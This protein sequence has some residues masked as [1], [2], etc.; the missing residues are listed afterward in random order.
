MSSGND[1][2]WATAV[3]L[4]RD[5]ERTIARCVST[6]S[7]DAFD[8]VLVLD[9][10]STDRTREIVEQFDDDR[11]EIQHVDWPDDFS[12][13]RNLAIEKIGSGWVVFID[14]DEWLPRA[15]TQ[16]LRQVLAEA[17]RLQG[18]EKAVLRPVVSEWDSSWSLAPGRIMLA[19]G[20]VRFAGAV[21][22]E[23]RLTEPPGAPASWIALNLQIKHDGYRPEVVRSKRKRERNTRLIEKCRAAE[24][25]NPRWIFFKVRDQ[26]ETLEPNELDRLCEKLAELCAAGGDARPAR[27]Y[28]SKTL[29]LFTSKLAYEGLHSKLRDVAD[30]LERVEVGNCDS[31]YYRYVLRLADVAAGHS[32]VNATDLKEMLLRTIDV[33]RSVGDNIEGALHTA[34]CHIDALIAALLDMLGRPDEANE[35]RRSIAAPWTDAFFEMSKP[36]WMDREGSFRQP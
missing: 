28:Y 14:S 15:S 25:D 22:E 16:S 32:H 33:R 36:R 11:I 24:P 23:P 3:V 5:D 27:S 10:G 8:E 2:A 4:A 6:L 1:R 17:S 19:D 34:G 21:H 13:V 9:T 12:E 35:Y 18:I 31:F 30:E 7:P 29:R 20:K 26:L